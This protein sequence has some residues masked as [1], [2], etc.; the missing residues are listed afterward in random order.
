LL[1]IKMKR[2]VRF[3]I[4]LVLTALIVLGL[5]HPVSAPIADPD[6]SV[7]PREINAYVCSRFSVEIW[8]TN[9]P[10]PMTWFNFTILW[11]PNLMEL[12]DREN[13][14]VG[15]DWEYLESLGDG[16]YSAEA[17]AYEGGWSTNAS[18]TKL[19]FH[20]LGEGTSE[21]YFDGASILIGQLPYIE[22]DPFICTVH[23]TVRAVGGVLATANKLAVLS[24]YLALIG[25]VGAVT[26]AVAIR[27]RKA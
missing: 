15:R 13:Y 21:I 14:A 8:I 25:L 26:V 6:I 3:V 24:P 7:E 22:L 11:D 17:K 9:L 23:Q 4:L 18:W 2:I 10:G 19:T 12:V 16:R 5:S 1:L 20:C 27:K